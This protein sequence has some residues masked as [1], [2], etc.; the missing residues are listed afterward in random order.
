MS[1]IKAVGFDIGGVVTSSPFPGIKKLE[2]DLNLPNVIK[3]Y[4]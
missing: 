2:R 3:N 1:D 4:D